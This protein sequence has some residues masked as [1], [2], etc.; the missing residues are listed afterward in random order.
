MRWCYHCKM[1]LQSDT[2]QM[3]KKQHQHEMNTDI[4]VHN[5]YQGRKS[6]SEDKDYMICVLHQKKV[7]CPVTGCHYIPFGMMRKSYM[8]KC[9]KGIIREWN[10]TGDESHYMNNIVKEKTRNGTICRMMTYPFFPFNG[11]LVPIDSRTRTVTIMG[12]PIK[13]KI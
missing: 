10:E 6:E 4:M 11:K 5:Q 12:V 3:H 8:L 9:A 2:F 1:Y 7:P 13:L